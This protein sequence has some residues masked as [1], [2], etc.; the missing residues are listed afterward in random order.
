MY[1]SINIEN[2]SDK[3]DRPDRKKKYILPWFVMI[4]GKNEF[5][6]F[7]SSDWLIFPNRV[8]SK[9]VAST[10]GTILFQRLTNQNE[11]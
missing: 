10:L 4:S 11:R 8:V 9:V 7:I 3:I 6:F 2:Q 1:S 5:F